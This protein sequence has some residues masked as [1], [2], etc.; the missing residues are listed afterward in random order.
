MAEL[1][2]KDGTIVKISDET[3]QEL[4]KVF[5]NNKVHL[6]ERIRVGIRQDRNLACD[7]PIGIGMVG[8]N[9]IEIGFKDCTTFDYIT[10]EQTRELIEILKNLLGESKWQINQ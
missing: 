7:Y 1:K 5:G 8:S 6:V 10:K 3:E 2:C 9:T 4:R